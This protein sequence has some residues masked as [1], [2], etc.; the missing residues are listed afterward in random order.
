[1]AK[2]YSSRDQEEHFEPR[3][4]QVLKRHY[5]HYSRGV[6]WFVVVRNMITGTVE[7]WYSKPWG[8]LARWQEKR[9]DSALEKADALSYAKQQAQERELA[10]DLTADVDVPYDEVLEGPE[11]DCLLCGTSLRRGHDPDI[12]QTCRAHASA[13]AELEAERNLYQI[14]P[15]NLMPKASYIS[16]SADYQKRIGFALLRVA[17]VMVES[18]RR[19]FNDPKPPSLGNMYRSGVGSH[20][21]YDVH[22][23]EAQF[24]GMQDLVQAVFEYG[25]AQR[26]W[27]KDDGSSL[28]RRLAKGEIHPDD[29]SDARR[30]T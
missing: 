7:E 23:S 17:G 30:K 26:S 28:L 24:E 11:R 19:K 21:I 27:G 1:M 14:V 3:R 15:E 5:Y 12:C 29:F 4:I 10:F 13:G 9:P 22:L 16:N 25:E 2:R 18:N 6:G 8:K 20:S